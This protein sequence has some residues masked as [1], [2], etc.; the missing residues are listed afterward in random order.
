MLDYIADYFTFEICDQV[1]ELIYDYLEVNNMGAMR[2]SPGERGFAIEHHKLLEEKLHMKDELGMQLSESCML[3]PV[4]SISSVFI[5]DKGIQRRK[6][7][8]ECKQCSDL[9]CKWRQIENESRDYRAS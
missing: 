3:Y 7:L 5:V 9:T 6:K 4:K 2:L 8:H 1:Y